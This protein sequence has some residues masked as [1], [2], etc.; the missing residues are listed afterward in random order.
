MYSSLPLP[1][2]SRWIKEDNRYLIDWEDKGVEEKV[3]NNNKISHQKLQLQERLH[4]KDL[5]LQEEAII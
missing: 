4:I 1:E 2:N 5:W 3:I